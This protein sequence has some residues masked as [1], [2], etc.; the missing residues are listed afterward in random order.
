MNP[1]PSPLGTCT[2][3][4]GTTFQHF[5]SSQKQAKG[6]VNCPC[7]PIVGCAKGSTCVNGFCKRLNFSFCIFLFQSALFS[8]AAMRQRLE[9]LGVHQNWLDKCPQTWDRHS[10]VGLLKG[11]CRLS[12]NLVQRFLLALTT[13]GTNFAHWQWAPKSVPRFW[14]KFFRLPAPQAIQSCVQRQRSR[15]VSHEV[16]RVAHHRTIRFFQ[17]TAVSAGGHFEV[18]RKPVWTG[19]AVC[20]SACEYT[21]GETKCQL[22]FPT[23][24]VDRVL[25]GAELNTPVLFCDS[26]CSST[27]L[28]C[29][30]PTPAATST[31]QPQ[32]MGTVSDQQCIAT[33]PIVMFSSFTC[34][35]ICFFCVLVF[36]WHQLQLHMQLYVP[37]G[38]FSR[39]V[40]LTVGAIVTQCVSQNVPN[41]CVLANCNAS[42]ITACNPPLVSKCT[43]DAGRM[44]HVCEPL[45]KDCCKRWRRFD[46][47]MCHRTGAHSVAGS[48]AHT[49]SKQRGTNTSS[50]SHVGQRQSGCKTKNC[51]VELTDYFIQCPPAVEQQCLE[52]IT[53]GA[54]QTGVCQCD[55]AGNIVASD[56]VHSTATAAVFALRATILPHYSS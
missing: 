6:T 36:V 51:V 23:P 42:P 9:I 14:P 50:S 17:T 18:G 19:P 47:R 21:C 54:Q 22:S 56:C 1:T 43:C 53:C 4:S 27:P 20:P 28:V 40:L 46:E 34:L 35:P 55:S 10:V 49:V 29:Q 15:P 3:S 52:V 11:S 26:R 5:S 8:H 7:H 31:M 25:C 33:A 30:A 39:H 41:T 2:G 13:V 16:F 37:S 32:C 45:K 24:T 38:V 44:R 12:D 48:A